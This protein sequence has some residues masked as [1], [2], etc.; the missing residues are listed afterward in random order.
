MK[1]FQEQYC[2]DEL[3][4][5]I[6]VGRLAEAVFLFGTVCLIA[7]VGR[8]GLTA[9]AEQMELVALLVEL[10]ESVVYYP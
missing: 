8:A 6:E 3:L 4:C 7:A 2:P 5:W 10:V 1:V 9:A